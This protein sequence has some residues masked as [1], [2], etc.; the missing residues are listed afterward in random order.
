MKALPQEFELAEVDIKPELAKRATEFPAEIN[1][2][3]H[4]SSVSRTSD[5]VHVLVPALKRWAIFTPSAIADVSLNFFCEQL[6]VIK[7]ESA[8]RTDSEL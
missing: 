1:D 5:A 8:Q 4:L 2:F 7:K 3:K 6:N